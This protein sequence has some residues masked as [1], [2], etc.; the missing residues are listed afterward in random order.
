MK[1]R[2]FLY[3]AF[4]I[5]DGSTKVA[6]DPGKHLWLFKLNSL[7]PKDE[8]KGVT[9]ILITHGDIDHFD[10]AIPMAKETGAEIICA[11]E[12]AEDF[13]SHDITK[14]HRI[15]VGESVDAGNVRA[16]GLKAKHGPLSVRLAAGLIEM[17]N[18]LREG[19]QGGQ[20][21]FFGPV[22]IQME[23]KEMQVR[24]H[25]TIKLLFGFIR[26]E[27][28]NVDFARGSI[29]FKFTIG[30]KTFINLGDTVIQQGWE[31][32]KPDV[33][34]IPIG[35]VVGNTMD[36]TEALVAVRLIEPAKVI[37]MHYNC[38]FLGIRNINPTD[39]EMFKSEVEKLGIECNIMQYGDEIDI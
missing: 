25:G 5:E 18:K 27:K 8:W 7:I 35:G 1:I 34:M 33:L 20:E 23:K 38:A 11:E 3:N 28:D 15:G 2:H 39:D 37:P 10:Y 22:R 12:L 9:H 6:I 26:L 31:G 17:K 30:D 4:L 19:T 29:G 13:I 36:V 32:L 16:E 14:V 21:V 24:N